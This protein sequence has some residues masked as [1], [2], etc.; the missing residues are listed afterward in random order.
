M[1]SI[2]SHAENST[3]RIITKKKSPYRP[4]NP[5]M[6]T[7]MII[8]LQISLFFTACE[9]KFNSQNIYHPQLAVASDGS[10]L[11]L[12]RQTSGKSSDLFIAKWRMGQNFSEP[13]RVNQAP[14]VVNS[15]NFEEMR[16]SIAT[17][18]DGLIAVAWTDRNWDV[19]AAVSKDFGRSFAPSVKLNQ[20]T[21]R[22]MQSFVTASIDQAGGLHCVWLDPRPAKPGHEEPADLYYA[23]GQNGRF[24]ERN[25]TAQQASSVCG[26]CRP[27]ISRGNNGAI[28]VVFRNSMPAGFRDIFKITQISARD[29]S[30]PK[31]LGPALWEITGCPS[32]GPIAY[33]DW[34]LWLDGS[35]DEMR[36]LAISDSASEPQVLLH[37]TKDGS[38]VR[39]PRLVKTANDATPLVLMPGEPAG[40]IL[41]LKNS[42]WQVVLADVPPW[43]RS[44]AWLE[45]QLF[46]TGEVENELQFETRAFSL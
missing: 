9:K 32:L 16:A 10:L 30:E 37:A 4:I 20:D 36:L 15:N 41:L 11:L 39:T 38:F 8:I 7:F 25:L 26:C 13:V 43:C 45:D 46:L 27:Y 44:A 31:Q 19:R 14:G 3:F 12:W 24:Q 1:H 22:A 2:V 21:T 29:F 18:P 42:K 5:A 23:F 33:Q 40:K 35:T 28:Q 17:G 34:T 6:K